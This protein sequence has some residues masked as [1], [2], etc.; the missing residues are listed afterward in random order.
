MNKDPDL[1]SLSPDPIYDAKV[2]I[3]ILWIFLVLKRLVKGQIPGKIGPKKILQGRK[4]I[5]LRIVCLLNKICLWL[6]TITNP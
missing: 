2:Q 3:N 5:L 1:R 6:P 4:M